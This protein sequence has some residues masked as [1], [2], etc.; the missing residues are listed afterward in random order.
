MNKQKTISFVYTSPTTFVIKD[1]KFL[2]LIGCNV[3]EIKSPPFKNIL[4]F[5][6]NRIKELV[7][8]ILILPKSNYTIIWF[9]DYHALIPL[10]LSKLFYVESI[11]MVGGY[12]AV[13]DK[14]INHGIFFQK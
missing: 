10:I 9:S 11:I 12:D 6:I 5:S 14:E 3:L 1:I 4:L 7:K 13:S 2:K 8:G